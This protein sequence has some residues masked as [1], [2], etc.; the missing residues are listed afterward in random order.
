ADVKIGAVLQP[1]PEV[2]RI[3][4]HSSLDVDFV[5]LVA[6]EGEIKAVQFSFLLVIEQFVAIE[7]IGGAMLFAEKEPVAASG[8]LKGAL[9]EKSAKRGETGARADHDNV[10]GVIFGQAK[11]TGFLYINRNIS[12]KQLGVIGEET[13]GKT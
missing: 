7:K 2:F 13:G 6:G 5:E 9:F 3:F 1:R 4:Q 8:A 10:G 12:Y 11:R